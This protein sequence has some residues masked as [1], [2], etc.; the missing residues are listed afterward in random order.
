MA[1]LILKQTIYNVKQRVQIFSLYG[2]ILF[3]TKFSFLSAKYRV[4]PQRKQS[5][6]PKV[7]SK[8][9]FMTAVTEF[10]FSWSD[11]S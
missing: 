10:A 8:A 5:E 4:T 6:T 3:L 1:D 2:E 7:L 11:T 9:R